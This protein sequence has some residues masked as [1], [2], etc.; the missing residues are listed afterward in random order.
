MRCGFKRTSIK[1]EQ[2]KIISETWQCSRQGE[3]KYNDEGRKIKLCSQ[4]FNLILRGRTN[5]QP[6]ETSTIRVPY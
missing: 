4:H 1:V 6:K 2:D 5:A 3:I